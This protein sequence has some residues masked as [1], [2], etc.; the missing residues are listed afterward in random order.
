VQALLRH[1]SQIGDRDVETQV[2]ERAELV[3]AP[4][5]IGMAQ[6]FLSIILE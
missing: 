6:A 5:G 4:Q 3:G 2:R 1:T